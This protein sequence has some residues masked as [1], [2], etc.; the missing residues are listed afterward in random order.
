MPRLRYALRVLSFLGL[1]LLGLAAACGTQGA[2]DHDRQRD[3]DS[4]VAETL[5]PPQVSNPDAPQDTQVQAVSD[6]KADSQPCS[7]DAGEPC[8]PRDV[9]GLSLFEPRPAAAGYYIQSDADSV[10]A[11]LEKGLRLAEA[12]PVHIAIRGRTA[13]STFRCAWRGVARTAG[14]RERAVRYWLGLAATDALPSATEVERRFMQSINNASLQ[15]LET[16]KANFK[17]LARGGLTTEYLFLTCYADYAIREY[18][19]GAGPSTLTVAYDHMAEARSYDLYKRA[20]TAGEF[21]NTALLGKSA[22]QVALENAAWAVESSL[23]A[24]VGDRQTVVFL[25][26]MAAHHAIAIEAWQAIDQ[27]DVQFVNGT[28]NA[29]RFGAYPG[30]PEHSQSLHNLRNRVTSAASTDSFA[31][32]RISNVSGLRKYYT[33]IGAYGDI[34]PDDGKT[35][36][37]TPSQPPPVLPCENG[38]AVPNPSANPGLVFDCRTLLGL[39]STLA[40]SATLNWSGSTAITAWDGVL[41][42]GSP[43]RVNR[44]SLN[45]KQLNGRIPPALA[46]LTKL[47]FLYLHDNRLQGSIPPELGNMAELQH[48]Y[49]NQNWLTGA[50]PAELGNLAN[51]TRLFLDRNQLSGAIPKELGSM[52]KLH[53]LYLN[54]NRL[55]GAIPKELG[56]LSKL[57]YLYLEHNELTGSIPKE[58]GKLSILTRM[59]IYDNQLSGAIPKELGSLTL[60]TRLDLSKNKLTGAIPPELGAMAKLEF[61]YLHCNALTSTIPAALGNITTLRE[62]YLLG[63]TITGD[64]PASLAG[65]DVRTG[66]SSVCTSV[67]PTP[68]PFP[69]PTPTPTPSSS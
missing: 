52:A 54:H 62:L 58:L 46:N 26:P 29:V 27:W 39:K 21:G 2:N 41:V 9:S 7:G 50:I 33:D 60:V 63:N 55:T 17:T 13:G 65:V 28:L 53:Q 23:S 35:D 10:E 67:S 19:L 12:S 18:L 68:T 49:L 48:L 32:K 37:F 61:L 47:H 31:G 1:F 8:A 11:V 66:A 16:E 3:V 30:D 4:P 34:T 51:L 5:A 6:A 14:Q 24:I 43:Q 15:F 59:D 57:W 64:V 22:Y 69:T 42:G 25:A 40:G 44:L 38:T 45:G 20:H 36:T 56:N